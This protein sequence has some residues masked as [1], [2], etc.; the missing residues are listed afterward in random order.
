MAVQYVGTLRYA[1]IFAKKY[2]TLAQYAFFVIVRVLYVGTVS[3]F[4]RGTLLYV[5]TLFQ[6]AY[7]TFYRVR[8]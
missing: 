7:Q 6:F 2:G 1:S 3:L 8:N 4:C 5:G